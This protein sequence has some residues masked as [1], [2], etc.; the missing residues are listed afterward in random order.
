MRSPRG[1]LDQL[2]EDGAAGI[3]LVLQPEQGRGDGLGLGASQPHHADP[4][5]AR[6]GGDGHDGV[7]EFHGMI[8]AA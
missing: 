2:A 1:W 5:P 3:E 7:I 6:R 4:A 8:L